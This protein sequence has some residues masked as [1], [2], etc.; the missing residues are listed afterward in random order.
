MEVLYLGP[1][2]LTLFPYLSLPLLRN[3]HQWFHVLLADKYRRVEDATY[4]G[5]RENRLFMNWK[6]PIYDQQA[7]IILFTI[8]KNI[9][10]RYFFINSIKRSNYCQ[11]CLNSE[12]NS[13]MICSRFQYLAASILF[14]KIYL[15]NKLDSLTVRFILIREWFQNISTTQIRIRLRI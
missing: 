6:V 13:L 4:M 7:S 3:S 2:E 11:L 12:I 1:W 5:E 9:L 8:F 14:W 10:Y 15:Q